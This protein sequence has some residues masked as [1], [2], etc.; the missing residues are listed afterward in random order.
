MA[1]LILVP[2]ALYL[3]VLAILFFAQTA[4]I[5]PVGH[6]APAAALPATAEPL[7]ARAGTGERLRGIH[8]PPARQGRER[9]LLLGFGGNAT[10]AATTAALLHD[11]FPEADVAA[12]HYRGYPPSEGRPGASAL[13]ADAPVVHDLLRARLHPARIVIAGFS[14][15]SGV[16][17]SLAAHRPIDGLILVTP[18][19]SLGAVAAG[20]Y[21]WLPVRLLLRHRL[22]PAAELRASRV[23][24]AIVA[25]GADTLV[26]RAR[27]DALRRAL[28]RLVFDRIIAGAGHNDIYA[29]PAFRTAMREALAAVTAARTPS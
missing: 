8:I 1:W 27:T 26:P 18:F 17:A 3:L 11:L 28:P 23:P 16:A 21:P 12:F 25:G 15:G 20:H 9:L 7:E 29:D 24:V 2:T 19:D 22:E 10:D 13:Q 5:F 4:L 14:V 6:V